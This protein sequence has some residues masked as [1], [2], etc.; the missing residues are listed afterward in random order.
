MQNKNDECCRKNKSGKGERVCWGSG[1]TEFAFLH[2]IIWQVGDEK[3]RRWGS[4]T[5]MA[6]EEQREQEVQ[7]A[8]GGHLLIVSREQEGDHMC[9]CSLQKPTGRSC[10]RREGWGSGQSCITWP[11]VC[12]IN[13][14]AHLFPPSQGSFWWC[15]NHLAQCE[16]IR[17]FLRKGLQMK[18][19]R[20]LFCFLKISCIYS[21]VCIFRPSALVQAARCPVSLLDP[22]KSCCLFSLCPLHFAR[23]H[24]PHRPEWSCRNT[25]L[26]IPS[27]PNLKSF[28]SF[29][30]LLQLSPKSIIEAMPSC[31]VCSFLVSSPLTLF[32]Q[33]VPQPHLLLRHTMRL[34]V[35]CPSW[36]CAC[37]H[38]V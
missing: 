31:Q 36:M 3:L 24:S 18:S 28:N 26:I 32:L 23:S 29:L 38:L 16:E 21:F 19:W 34:P 4:E 14:C 11:R 25:N 22:W 7:R 27:C 20:L 17:A 6:E 12:A 30:W 10:H 13:H 35:S 2:S 37:S 33:P 5:W 9:L 15:E 8:R 1:Q